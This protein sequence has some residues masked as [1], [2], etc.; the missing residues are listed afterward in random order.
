MNFNFMFYFAK[1]TGETNSWLLHTS[2]SGSSTPVHGPVPQHQATK[3]VDEWA[4]AHE[5]MQSCICENGLHT[6]NHP[7]SPCLHWSIDP[8][9]LGTTVLDDLDF[10]EQA[11][12]IRFKNLIILWI[13]PKVFVCLSYW[14]S[15]S[16]VFPPF[17]E[18]SPPF[19]KLYDSIIASW[20]AF[21]RIKF[22][23]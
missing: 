3:M 13:L 1:F 15:F 23:F 9:R 5:R 4:S 10:L 7:P 12:W 16:S 8:E 11:F 21:L 17:S 2:R 18:L 22:S 6:W 20:F 14:H 19:S